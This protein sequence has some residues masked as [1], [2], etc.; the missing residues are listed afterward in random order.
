MSEVQSEQQRCS[1]AVG[2][3]MA[4]Y[5]DAEWGVPLRDDNSLFELITLEGAQ[6]GL[7]WQTVLRKRENYRTAFAG[8]DPVRVAQ[9][10]PGDVDRL[11]LNSGLIRHRGKLE[12]TVTNAQAFLRIQAEHGS[13]ADYIWA[14]VEGKPIHR[15]PAAPGDIPASNALSDQVSKDLR[16]R[17]FKFV[18]TTICYSFL[19][20]AGLVNDH[21]TTC[22]R[23]AQLCQESDLTAG[24]A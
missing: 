18:G 10:A 17:G 8:F 21:F 6:A 24:G 3:E 13:F 19:Q 23:H 22:F 2:E 15:N 9:L 11:M 20:A 16:K 7:S 4:A 1:W 12:S 14:F 5:H